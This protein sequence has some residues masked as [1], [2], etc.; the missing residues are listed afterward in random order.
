MTIACYARKSNN[1]KSESVENQLAIIENYIASRKD[2]CGASIVRFRDDGISGISIERDEF[3]ELLTKVRCREID[4]IVVKD[5]SRLGRNYLDVVRLTESVFPFMKVRVIAVSDDYDSDVSRAAPMSLMVS[6]KAILNEFYAVEA[7]DKI[8]KAVAHKVKKGEFHGS[9][10]YGYE[11]SDDV[12][13]K[14][15]PVIDPQKSAVVREIFEQYLCGN[16]TLDIARTLNLRGEKSHKGTLWSVQVIRRILANK[17]YTGVRTALKYERDYKAKKLV[18]TAETDRLIEAD[19]F[20]PIIA[21]EDFERVQKLLPTLNKPNS[22]PNHVMAGKLFC[23]YCGKALAKRKAVK[24]FCSAPSVS[25]LPPCFSGALTAEFLYPKVLE[26]VKAF[27]GAELNAYKGR[28][29]FSDK[30][31]IETEIAKLREKKAEVFEQLMDGEITQKEFTVKKRAVADKITARENELERWRKL[32]AF[33]TKFDNGERPFDT[34]KRLCDSD[35]LT[36]EH[37]QFVEIIKVDNADNF[38]IILYNDSPLTVLCR[39]ISIYEEI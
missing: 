21:A 30:E 15:K 28:F 7:S 25:G 31:K 16:S 17:S 32:A 8:K 38:E 19:F 33:R 14:R 2:F 34:L 22:T 35:E 11:L 5:L 23:G 29:S 13:G 12:S 9:L 6:L 3:G 37:M 4:V 10:P 26:K 36:K 27:I 39:G 20:P 1:K 24:F 18:P